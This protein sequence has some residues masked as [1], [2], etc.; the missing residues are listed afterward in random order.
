MLAAATALL[1]IRPAWAGPPAT[2]PA[3]PVEGVIVEARPADA[4]VPAR[5]QA[6]VAGVEAPNHGD[7]LLR[8]RYPVCPLVAGLP[9]E[10]AEFVLARLS[11][12]A[13]AS[14]AAIGP[15]DCYPNFY[16]VVTDVPQAL[17]RTWRRRD[18]YLF[19]DRAIAGRAERFIRT[20]RAVRVWHNWEFRPGSGDGSRLSAFSVRAGWGAVVIVDSRKVAGISNGQL[21]DYIA[22]TGLA[23]VNP[24][25]PTGT[26]PTILHLFDIPPAEAP[27][28]LSD[29]D[30][31]YLGALYHSQQ[32][33]A[34]QRDQI[35]ARMVKDLTR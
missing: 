8:W 5:V 12:V 14:G 10:T 27:I 2:S 25:A 3:T 6:F 26:A 11:Q 32:E 21:A 22:M 34:L 17:L 9:R 35:A 29:W 20:D 4:S 16:V 18:I 13:A 33:S 28:G 23:E 15:R 31:A 30:R 1:L 19:G 7:S 24:D